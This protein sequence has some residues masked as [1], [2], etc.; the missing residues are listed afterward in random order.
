MVSWAHP[1]QNFIKI[2]RMVA[3]IWRFNGFQN[4]GRPPSWIFEIQIFNGASIASVGSVSPMPRLLRLDYNKETLRE[5]RPIYRTL[6]SRSVSPRPVRSSSALSV[7]RV[8][9]PNTTSSIDEF[10]AHNTAAVK[11][12]K[13]AHTRLPSVGFR[14]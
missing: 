10:L 7:T 14:S 6:N 13:V 12:V 2:G 11:K 3:E 9:G 4:G 1:S 8:N 5:C